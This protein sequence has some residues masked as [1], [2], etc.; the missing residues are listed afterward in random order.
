MD[1]ELRKLWRAYKLDSTWENTYHLLRANQRISGQVISQNTLQ[2]F[3]DLVTPTF[4]G[5]IETLRQHSYEN[6]PAE[7]YDIEEHLDD[8]VILVDHISAADQGLIPDAGDRT[9]S[10]IV[11]LT[12]MDDIVFEHNMPTSIALG[13]RIQDV[14]DTLWSSTH[15]DLRQHLEH[16]QKFSYNINQIYDFTNRIWGFGGVLA[17]PKSEYIRGKNYHNLKL[18]YEFHP[19][20]TLWGLLLDMEFG[21]SNLRNNPVGDWVFAWHCPSPPPLKNW[22]DLGDDYCDIIDYITEHAEEVTFDEFISEIGVNSFLETSYAGI[23]PDLIEI[24][25]RDEKKGW[26]NFDFYKSNYPDGK[27]VM[28][29]THSGIEHVWEKV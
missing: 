20:A 13:R 10:L 5:T 19:D 18:L 11:I 21:K 29:H 27:P 17:I 14:Q 3:A 2:Q 4:V 15:G 26:L 8:S 28:F 25:A 1:L 12:L 7:E 9:F 22:G 6:I 16:S 24:I 23:T